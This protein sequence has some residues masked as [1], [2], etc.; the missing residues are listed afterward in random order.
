MDELAAKACKKQ[1][2]LIV[3]DR[4]VHGPNQNYLTPKKSCSRN[5]IS[6]SIV[7]L[8]YCWRRVPKPQYMSPKEAIHMLVDIVAKGNLKWENTTEEIKVYIPNKIRKNP[9][10]DL[11]WAVSISQVK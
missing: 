2:G 11:A 10:C 3:V 1:P 8:Y 6:L 9:P 4:A 5:P 7:V